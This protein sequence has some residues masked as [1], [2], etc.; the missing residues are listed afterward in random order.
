MKDLNDKI[1]VYQYICNTKI[2][3]FQKKFKEEQLRKQQ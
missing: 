2:P 3:N 1:D